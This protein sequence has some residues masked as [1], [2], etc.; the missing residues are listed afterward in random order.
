MKF[1]SVLSYIDAA[2]L[3]LIITVV[4][5]FLGFVYYYSFF[6]TYGV[7]INFFTL[8]FE[9]Y[10]LV[11]W[12]HDLMAVG[13]IV[14]AYFIY[15]LMDLGEGKMLSKYAGVRK[16]LT[17]NALGIMLMTIFT[18]VLILAIVIDRNAT[19]DALSRAGNRKK[20]EF[21]LKT[22]SA[23]P[24]QLYFLTYSSGKYIVYADVPA[25]AGKSP[26]GQVYVIND[27]DVSMIT[28]PRE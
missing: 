20:I 11:N 27:E 2:A 10:I 28:F 23:L 19:G 14:I 1:A 15:G 21:T 7:D 13:V 25:E 8:P 5:Y 4:L 22:P 12:W 18:G 26:K 6:A 9:A 17:N 24:A 3:M 16:W